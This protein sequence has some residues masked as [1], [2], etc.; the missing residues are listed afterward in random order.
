MVIVFTLSDPAQPYRMNDSADIE[1]LNDAIYFSRAGQEFE[2]QIAR[3]L[4][5][6]AAKN[7]MK[8]LLGDGNI[9]DGV[10][11]RLGAYLDDLEETD[12]DE[13]NKM[14]S[15]LKNLYNKVEAGEI[16]KNAEYVD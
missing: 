1:F 6:S 16:V 7:R 5:I 4:D 12:L 15:G 3:Q 9:P 11:G 13:F 8:S 2:W 14:V 10:D